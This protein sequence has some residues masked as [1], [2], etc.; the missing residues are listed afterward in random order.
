MKSLARKFFSLIPLTVLAASGITA[1]VTHFWWVVPIG[2]LAA[3]IIAIHSAL[4]GAE[5]IT[6]LTGKIHHDMSQFTSGSKKRFRTLLKKKQQIL[7][8]LNDLGDSPLLPVDDMAERVNSLVESYYQLLIKLHTI[9]PFIDEKAV[10]RVRR[11]VA[12]LKKQVDQST[13]DVTKENLSLAL[14]NK[15]DE[16][17]RL[18]ELQKHAKRI[19]SQLV[20]VGTGLNSI[21][22]AIVQ[23]KV[24]PESSGAPA[25]EVKQRI[26]ELLLDVDISERVVRELNQVSLEP[27]VEK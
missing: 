19:D 18:T 9:L 5:T 25:Q 7:D 21:H 16:L 2:F 15:S 22:A 6:P 10:D 11:S 4:A 17:N 1:G 23:I 12:M 27:P 26:G 14:R 13:D 3:S 8:T 24:S 20:T